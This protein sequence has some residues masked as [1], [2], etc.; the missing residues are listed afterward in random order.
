[1]TDHHLQEQLEQQLF[2]SR[3]LWLASGQKTFRERR[4]ILTQLET[5]VTQHQSDICEAIEKDFGQRSH[6]ETG[7]LEVL[8]SLESIRDAK[9]GVKG[10]MKPRKHH[11]SLWFLPA[12]NRVYPQPV[13]VV[14][15][16]VPWNYPL[17]LTMAPLVSALAA[18]NHAMVK[19]SPRSRHYATLIKSLFRQ[20][21]PDDLISIHSDDDGSL[22]AIFSQLKFD[23]LLFTGSTETGKKVMRS[24]SENLVPVTLEL[25]GKSPTIIAPDADLKQAL[26]KVIGGKTYNA[27]QTCVA[28]DYLLVPKTKIEQVVMLSQQIMAQRFST[29][30]HP[31]YTSMI[32]TTAFERAQALLKDA[33]SKG[34]SVHNLIPANQPELSSRLFPLHLVTNT[35]H[36]MLVE[37]QEVFSPILPVIGYD[38]IEHAIE[39]V[40]SKPK[41]LALY[42]F[43]R[44]QSVESSVLNRTLSG[45][46]CIN[47]VMI[48]V[49]QHDLPF[50]GVG[51]SGI[52]HYHGIHGFE[53]LSKMRPV[54]KQSSLALTTLFH[55]PYSNLASRLLNFIVNRKIGRYSKDERGYDSNQHSIQTNTPQK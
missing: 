28:P 37:Q 33:V 55:A 53:R 52:G 16:M 31:D 50:G 46:V 1:M 26:S 12:K 11:T 39:M 17:L 27:G 8:T 34:A 22:G 18:G 38:S 2:Q 32:D 51:E 19:L 10:W 24:A 41:P 43:T 36:T 9:R 25:G 15:I 40:Q 3:Q 23:H 48:H 54:T 29:I 14:G 6:H 7:A 35:N 20:Y 13:G 30:H 21:F 47:D 42:L 45:G 49:A 44:D 5:L 4:H